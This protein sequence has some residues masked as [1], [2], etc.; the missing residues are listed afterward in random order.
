[1]SKRLTVIKLHVFYKLDDGS[2]P[3][4]RDEFVENM[5]DPWWKLVEMMDA[6]FLRLIKDFSHAYKASF[7][8][9][10]VTVDVE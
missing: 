4:L 10:C 1:L 3:V 9:K 6:V 5:L 7:G 8:V 2:E